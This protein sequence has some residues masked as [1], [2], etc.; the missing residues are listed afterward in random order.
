MVVPMAAL[1]G[2]KLAVLL[3]AL[4]ADPRVFSRD[5][6]LACCLVDLWDASLAETLDD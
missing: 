2:A 5:D 1:L 6:R 3:G 4:M